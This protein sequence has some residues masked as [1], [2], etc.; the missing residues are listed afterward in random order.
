MI[1]NSFAI[2]YTVKNEASLLR[3]TIPYF[4][5]NGASKIYIYWDGTTDDA[6]NLVCKYPDVIARN[7]IKVEDLAF[8]PN[9]VKKLDPENKMDHRKRINVLFTCEQAKK[10]GIEWVCCIDPDEMILVNPEYTC[11]TEML[12]SLDSKI[13]QVLMPNLELLPVFNQN[14]NPF[15]SQTLFIERQEYTR[16]LWRF[17]NKIISNKLNPNNLASLENFIYR[18]ANKGIFPPIY[19]NPLNNKKIYRSLFLGYNNFKAFIRSDIA[20][21]YNYNIHKW[22]AIDRKPVTVKKGNILHYDLPSYSYFINK[23]NQRPSNMQLEVFDTR[24]Q[25]GEIARDASKKVS[26]K[27]YYENICCND[28]GMKIKLKK[29]GVIREINTISN[30]FKNTDLLI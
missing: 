22:D 26:E 8:I 17:I 14:D 1:K 10:D 12:N 21:D 29:A 30:F 9:W 19:I 25:L 13:E 20:S 15:L 27:F 23:F 4:L 11:I 7:S 28:E 2:V 16:N 5:K 18:F 6:T 24:Y 3:Y